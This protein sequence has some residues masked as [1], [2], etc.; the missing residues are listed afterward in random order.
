LAS[1]PNRALQQTALCAAA[2]RQYRWADE[3]VGSNRMNRIYR[4]EVAIGVVFAVGSAVWG[5]LV[6]VDILPAPAEPPVSIVACVIVVFLILNLSLWLSAKRSLHWP[7]QPKWQMTGTLIATGIFVAMASYGILKWPAAPVRVD[8][9]RYVD[10][11][12]REHTESSF[13]AFKR[14]ETA[15]PFLWMPFALSAITT[16]PAMA[17][18]HRNAA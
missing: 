16:L 3:R 8:G 5:S 18:P 13:R 10:K 4:I 2:E 6:L 17:R 7:W 1:L 15:F 11:T 14:W 9:Q 12:G